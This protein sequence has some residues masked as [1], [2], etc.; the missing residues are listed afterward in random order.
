MY[1]K[2]IIVSVIVIVL[3]HIMPLY[4]SHEGTYPV[5]REHGGFDIA[6]QKAHELIK[7]NPDKYYLVDVRT[8]YEY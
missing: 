6:P 8:R 3:L 4:A 2:Y 5:K 7:N 1:K